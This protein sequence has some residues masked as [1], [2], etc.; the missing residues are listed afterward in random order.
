MRLGLVTGAMLLAVS[1][2]TALPAQAETGPRGWCGWEPATDEG[3]FGNAATFTVPLRTGAGTH[4]QQIGQAS[5][6]DALHYRCFTTDRRGLAWTYLTDLAT[7]VTGWSYSGNLIG[8][9][10]SLACQ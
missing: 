8:N 9:G 3:T 4:C 7:G 5:P 1:A 2:T 10:A 6:D